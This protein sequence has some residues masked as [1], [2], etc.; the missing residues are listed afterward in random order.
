MHHTHPDGAPYPG[1]GVPLLRAVSA[2]ARPQLRAESVFD[3]A[4]S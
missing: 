3:L 4:E 1:R 2:T